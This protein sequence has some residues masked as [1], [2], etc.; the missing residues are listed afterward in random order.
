V[1]PARAGGLAR[2]LA[3]L[4]TCATCATSPGTQVL[5]RG[6]LPY[7]VATTGDTVVTV[8]LA[9]RFELVV[10][11][12]SERTS[13]ERERRLDLG[14]PEHDLRALAVF[15]QRAFIGSDAGF[16][17]E[18]D[19]TSMTEVRSYAVG[20]PLRA[21]AADA[22]YVL[23][24]DASGA[25]CLRRRSDGALLQCARTEQPVSALHLDGKG[26]RVW[27]TMTPVAASASASAS[28]SAVAWS[29]PA[30]QLILAPPPGN[31]STSLAFR[32]GEVHAEGR[33]LL[34]RR[35]AQRQVLAE[36]ATDVRGVAVTRS[37]ALIVAAWPKSL[38][39]AVLLMIQR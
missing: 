14:P 5:A 31:L 27:L 7:G 12:E 35:G 30:L 38:E 2:A 24:A 39:D 36:L 11:D 33:R 13:R 28:E 18:V 17:R 37:G 19:L 1:N 20:A 8:E 34:W 15:E 26:E 29:I 3:L 16:I 6:V 9:E 22:R 21:L 25:V 32:N 4:F 10:R 23:S